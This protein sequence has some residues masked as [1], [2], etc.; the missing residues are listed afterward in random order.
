MK[1]KI[2][3]SIVIAMAIFISTVVNAQNNASLPV[4]N[5]VIKF[6]SLSHNFGKIKEEG[7]K[8]S[9]IF[10]FKNTGND[11]L[12]ILGVKPGYG[13]AAND[14]TKTPVLPGKQGYIKAE[15]DPKNKVG[16][17]NKSFIVTTNSKEASVLLI[18]KGEVLPHVR[19]VADT[20]PVISGN[21]LMKTNHVAFMEIKNTVVRTDTLE[22]YN[23]WYKP[24]TIAFSSLPAFLTI[25]AIPE[26]LLPNKKGMILVTYDATKKN[27]YGLVYDNTNILTNDSADA[28]KQLTI[29]A[30]VVE[31]FSKLTPKQ[32]KNAPKIVFTT[33]S[34]DF[35][36]V[37]EGDPV[38]FT[39]ELKNNGIDDLII[40]KT[41]AS[42][43]CT[44]S[45]PE[46]TTLKKGESSKIDIDFNSNGK[47]GEQ[48]KTVTVISN[49][50]DKPSIVLNIK[51]TVTHKESNINTT[52]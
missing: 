36:T 33:E 6:D 46:K 12:K 24:M 39:F 38:K 5:A 22:I 50:P 51:G 11:T 9:T 40:R 7:G 28:S 35:G 43:G 37:K 34:Y 23:N 8:V 4:K 1:T 18:I 42:C 16:P 49:D 41:K 17:F 3:F 21:L 29:S 13:C 14:W 20:F 31:D 47:K 10:N 32:K 44:A 19:T 15:Y 45:N 27:D 25:K 2:Y 48:H 26:T 30:N 52:K